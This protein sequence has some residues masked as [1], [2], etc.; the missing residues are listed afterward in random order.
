[1]S[2]LSD[3]TLEHLRQVADLPDLT[4][5]K[6]ELVEK[7]GHGGM[8]SVYLAKD[9]EL[10]RFV[11]LKVVNRHLGN[12][13]AAS[14]RNDE[15]RVIA[16]LEHPGI[17]PVH[18]SGV[19]AD[20]RSFYAMKF[21]QGQR[22][23]NL[24]RLP[25]SRDQRLFLFQKVCQAVAFAHAQGVWH[26]DLKPQNIMIGSFGEVL[27]MDWGL[28]LVKQADSDLDAD[29]RTGW[30]T[31][32]YRAPEQGAQ[33]PIDERADVYALGGILY[34]LLTCRSPSDK[35]PR[36]I[37]STVARSLEAICLKARTLNR[38]E[39]YGNVAKL[40][41]DINCYL[42]KQPVVAYPEGPLRASL[43]LIS[44]YRVPIAL[45]LA[46]LIMRIV[47]MIWGI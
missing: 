4:G 21:I 32:G 37:D 30:G 22:L 16:R 44:K 31:P 20:G 27:V 5:T 11:A 12:V 29:G 10:D 7:I 6:Y 41:E 26:R 14:S 19:L 33:E 43:R 46:Y 1:V 24:A 35:R 36:R 28:A 45:V 15:A 47:L 9:K 39:R 8:A 3:R 2:W 38:E 34:F 25:E 13:E 40:M 42:E 17:V 18:D 23:D